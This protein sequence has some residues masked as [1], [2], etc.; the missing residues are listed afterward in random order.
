[1]I[2]CH[3]VLILITYKINIFEII[4]LFFLCRRDI[5][6]ICFNCGIIRS[7]WNLFRKPKLITVI[8]LVALSRLESYT[9]CVRKVTKNELEQTTA[10]DIYIRFRDKEFKLSCSETI[11]CSAH[12]WWRSKYDW[13]IVRVNVKKYFWRGQWIMY[14]MHGIE[15]YNKIYMLIV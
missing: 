15:T 12:I 14:C 9:W 7:V 5:F 11:I 6:Q 2:K 4:S 10:K 13:N 8:M 1:M 3:I